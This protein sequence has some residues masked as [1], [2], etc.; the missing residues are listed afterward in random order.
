[1]A[2]VN[3]WDEKNKEAPLKVGGAKNRG[4]YLNCKSKFSISS[5]ETL[6]PG[7]RQV[8]GLNHTKWCTAIMQVVARNAGKINIFE[9]RRTGLPT[10]WLIKRRIKLVQNTI[11]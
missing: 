2:D 5:Y 8:A 6:V 10:T 7:F 9:N 4:I 1:M 11:D 3:V